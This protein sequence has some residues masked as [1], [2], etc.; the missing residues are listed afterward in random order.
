MNP[1]IPSAI[2]AILAAMLATQLPAIAQGARDVHL[3]A[4]QSQLIG[5]SDPL[6]R[7]AVADPKVADVKVI[8]NH[9][10]LLQGIK[11]GTTTLYVWT[12]SG[13]AAAYDISIGLDSASVQKQVREL[14]GNDSLKVAFNGN[15]FLITGEPTSQTQKDLA[16]K[17]VASYNQ[18]V[19]NLTNVIQA[20]EQISIDVDVLELSR[21]AALN[22]G[23]RVGGGQPTNS[24]PNLRQYVFKP[25][26]MQFGEAATG[27]INT[28]GQ[29]DFLSLQL[30]AMQQRG[31]AKLLAHPTLVTT[32]GGKASF[33]AGGEVPIP[34]Q[35]ALGQTTIMW[36]EF[37]VRLE[38]APT[39]LPD[40][41]IRMAVKPEVSSLDFADGLKQ[42]SFT[43]PAIK[44]RRAD[45]QVILAPDETLMLG[46]LMD[47]DQSRAYDLLPGIGQIPILGELFKSRQFQ[48]NQ[49]ELAILVRPH[50]VT[51]APKPSLPGDLPAVNSEMQKVL[52]PSPAPAPRAAAPAAN[53][54]AALAPSNANTATAPAVRP[55]TYAPTSPAAAAAGKPVR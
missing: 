20:R 5:T 10:V 6:T 3:N 33:L 1:S 35:Q 18:P 50:L 9:Q 42:S 48:D 34:I 54:K 7:V 53:G 26:E 51:P 29:L 8:S 25:G 21:T 36:K 37:G 2:I 47:A 40:G 55:A 22:L 15:G 19:L 13:L 43:V 16:E 23:T 14:T 38:V 45:T 39:R 30:Q 12:R 46:G 24:D 31:E 17:I 28:F 4:G 32:D 11:P 44:T 27:H 52:A 49:T 41:R